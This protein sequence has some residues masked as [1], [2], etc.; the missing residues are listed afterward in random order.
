M[1]T[2]VNLKNWRT[3]LDS[4][5]K[6]SE[7]TN[8]F[9]GSMGAGKSSIMDAIC[10]GLFGVFP[11][12][13]QRKVKLEDIIMKKPYKK[14]EA[15]VN[16]FFNIDGEEWDVKRSVVKGKSTAELRKKGELVE[17]PQPSKVNDEINK[18]LKIDYDL[19]TRAIY[20][21]QNQLDHFLTIAKGQRMKKIDQ[22]LAIDKFDKA[23]SSS[24]SLINKCLTVVNEKR[25][26]FEKLQDDEGLKRLDVIERELA[27]LGSK[28]VEIKNQLK[29]ASRN[30]EKM[31]KDLASLKQQNEKLQIMDNQTQT[32][33]KLLEVTTKDIEGLQ[34]DLMEVAESTKDD[35]KKELI[36]LTTR[37]EGISSHLETEKEN[38]NKLKEKYIKQDAKIDMNSKKIP[39]LKKLVDEKNKI[40]LKLKKQS[41]NKLQNKLDSHKELLEKQ[42]FKFQKSNAKLEEFTNN[43]KDLRSVRGSCPI[44][45]SELTTDNKK[46]L[47]IKRKDQIKK[48]KNEITNLKPRITSTK[49][50]ITKLE[51]T[52]EKTKDLE[53]RFKELESS[54]NEL[55]KLNSELKELKIR[56]QSY[57]NEEKMLTKTTDMLQKNLDQLNERNN[58]IDKLL[59]KR[60]EAD[61]K[62]E[63]IRDYK[64][65]L[66][67]LE[68]E[69]QKISLPHPSYIERLENDYQSILKLETE[70]KTRLEGLQSMI[71]DKKELINEI[72]NKKQMIDNYK[73]EINKIETLGRQL[74]VLENCLLATQEQLRKDF[75]IAV[76]HAMEMIWKDLYPYKDFY[77]VRLGIQE[78][79]YILQLQDSTGWVPADGVASGGERTMA[80]LALRIAFSLVLAPQLK[81]L[82]LDEPTHNL[83]SRAVEDLGDILREKI[84]DFVD[85]VFLITHDSSLESAVSGY[86]YKLERDKI[87][88]G[89]TKIGLSSGPD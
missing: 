44:C 37:I 87:K 2:R 55:N 13:Q 17:G 83:D 8:C 23:R 50:M 63:R 52:L 85:Q 26:I 89:V 51:N 31:I 45:D 67:R 7:G 71:D 82:V 46:S 10:F 29:K 62:L 53:K 4:D 76:N 22:L 3:H 21:E 20:S 32:Y 68:T 18:L 11:Q 88:D 16:V 33:K 57:R 78:G 49:R 14:D 54:K 58:K 61:V 25:K 38:L 80:C 9:I 28:E 39:E 5:I 69:R 86:L 48:L 75:V 6:F 43:L 47:I 81:W 41:S 66:K 72:Q 34:E 40:K 27:N 15:E 12:L 1:I 19:F 36:E 24:R 65:K 70:F 74:E 77:N 35:M 84:T 42:E 60:E 64:I 59:L 79:D 30:K 73:H 56:T